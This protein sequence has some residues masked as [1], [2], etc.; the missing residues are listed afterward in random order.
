MMWR[1]AAA[2][3]NKYVRFPWNPNVDRLNIISPFTY[4]AMPLGSAVL[5]PM[6]KL[7]KHMLRNKTH[8][9]S[10]PRKLIV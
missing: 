2:A 7:T 4:P 6:L 10:T 1:T 5:C 3:T 9:I 8:E